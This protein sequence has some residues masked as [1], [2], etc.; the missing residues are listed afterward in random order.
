MDKFT[1]VRTANYLMADIPKLV[2]QN[3]SSYYSVNGIRVPRISQVLSSYKADGLQHWRKM[4]GDDVANLKCQIGI[5]RG[6]DVHQIIQ[7]YLDNDCTC[8][9]SDKLL[10]IGMFEAARSTLDRI[11]RIRG[12]ELPLYNK[13]FG[14][15]GTADCI[16]EFDGV[17]SIIDYKTCERPKKIE[18]C[19]RYFLQETFYSLTWEEMTEIP[20]E[21][22]VT[23]VISE[24][25]VV[26]VIKEQRDN[27]VQILEELVSKFHQP[28]QIRG[29]AN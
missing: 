17:Q 11:S 14:I 22:L 10:A 15:A 23:I 19:E 25:G 5:K 16:A 9:Y 26:Q 4:V 2:G 18:W 13:R 29:T 21:Q 20:V 3:G 6:N 7:S 1:H 27:W 8:K 28:K 24:T 12:T